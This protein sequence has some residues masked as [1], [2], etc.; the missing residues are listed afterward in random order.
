MLQSRYQARLAKTSSRFSLLQRRCLRDSGRG[1]GLRRRVDEGGEAGR[2]H[3]REDDVEGGGF[4]D[5]AEF[6]GADHGVFLAAEAE[7]DEGVGDADAAE[8]ERVRAALSVGVEEGWREGFGG[9]EEK[10]A[11]RR[12]RGAELAANAGQIANAV[13]RLR[14][15]RWGPRTRRPGMRGRPLAAG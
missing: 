6:E 10:G 11:K 9:Q 14:G 7:G 15:G 3:E 1:R 4:L 5:A 12:K 13:S 2:G 8:I